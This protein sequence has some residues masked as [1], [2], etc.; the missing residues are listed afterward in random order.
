MAC[1][2]G[3]YMSLEKIAQELEGD[4][5]NQRYLD[6]LRLTKSPQRASQAAAI[7]LFTIRK[8]TFVAPLQMVL[9]FQEGDDW[10]L[11]KDSIGLRFSNAYDQDQALFAQ[12]LTKKRLQIGREVFV[13][14]ADLLDQKE[15]L[16]IQEQ[17]FVGS[18]YWNDQLVEFRTNGQIK[19]MENAGIYAYTPIINEYGTVAIDQLLLTKNNQ[20]Q[21]YGFQFEKKKLFIYSLKCPANDP[22]CV[23]SIELG[24]LV[25]ELTAR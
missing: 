13:Q 16:I 23:E 1:N 9:S 25:F 24:D 17:L 6:T 10:L 11:Q 7:K 19:G 4:W 15:H 21:R 12:L 3:R 20:D 22:Y 2:H 18:Y 5:V 14:Y 8:D